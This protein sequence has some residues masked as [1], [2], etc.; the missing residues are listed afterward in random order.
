MEYSF[1]GVVVAGCVIRRVKNFSEEHSDAWIWKKTA[2][3]IFCMELKAE[4]RRG[5]GQMSGEAMERVKTIAW[6]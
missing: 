1:F 2:R 4:D 6:K 5:V 3:C